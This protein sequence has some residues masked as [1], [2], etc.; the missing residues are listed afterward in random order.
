MLG[1][2]VHA[3]L[4]SRAH[5]HTFDK[6]SA[7]PLTLGGC[8]Q[9]PLLKAVLTQSAQLLLAHLSGSQGPAQWPSAGLHSNLLKSSLYWGDQNETQ[10]SRYNLK[11]QIEGK[12]HFPQ[13]AGYTSANTAQHAV[14]LL[15]CKDILLTHHQ[16]ESGFFS[17]KLLSSKSTVSWC[18]GLFHPK[19]RTFH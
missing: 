19:H 17:A 9:P 3:I 18:M 14:G 15:C 1:Q 6:S 10:Y 2:S 4:F 8:E 5:L 16:P 7:L 13:T 12:N 11:L